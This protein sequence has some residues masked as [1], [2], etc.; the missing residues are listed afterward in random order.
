ME[1]IKYKFWKYLVVILTILVVGIFLLINSRQSVEDFFLKNSNEAAEI[2][3]SEEFKTD[4]YLVFYF[5]KEGY[6][7]CAVIKKNLI[8]YQVLRTSGRLTLETKGYLCSFYKDKGENQWLDWGIIT[9]STIENVRADGM[10]MNIIDNIPY[11]FRIF[12][13]TGSGA[14]PVNH[15]E[16][17]MMI[18]SCP[19]YDLIWNAVNCASNRPLVFSIGKR[20]TTGSRVGTRSN[21]N[22]SVYF[23]VSMNVL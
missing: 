17:R 21:T 7:S 4:R 11:G 9:D 18:S 19:L 6:I 20:K 1:S 3:Y 16:G 8:G 23:G 5:D 15:T 2:L 10:L 22:R 14:E 13:L 12:W